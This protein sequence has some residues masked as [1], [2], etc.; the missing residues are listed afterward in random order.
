[1]RRA[2]LLVFLATLACG[3]AERDA[4]IADDTAIGASPREE[5]LPMSSAELAPG[6]TLGL[7]VTSVTPGSPRSPIHR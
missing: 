7:L 6:D 1:M 2:G 5:V 4:P 3:R